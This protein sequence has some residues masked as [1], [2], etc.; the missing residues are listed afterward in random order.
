MAVIGFVLI[1]VGF[2]LTA[3]S[4]SGHPTPY[5]RHHVFTNCVLPGA[6]VST[7]AFPGIVVA[8]IFA[9]IW[10]TIAVI[11][12][13]TWRHPEPEW[14]YWSQ[15]SWSQ[16]AI[17]DVLVRG[18]GV[19][20]TRRSGAP[21]G[22]PCP[23]PQRVRRLRPQATRTGRDGG[24]QKKMRVSRIIIW[25]VVL[26]PLSALTLVSGGGTA[27]A[28]V[29]GAGIENCTGASGSIKYSPAWSDADSSSQIKAK[30]KITFSGCS[31]GTP[32]ASQ[33]NA[34]GTLKF[35]P[36]QSDNECT[37]AEEAGAVGSLKLKYNGGVSPSTYTGTIWVSNPTDPYFE[38]ESGN[39]VVTGS[40][41]NNGGLI[42]G[43]PELV[44]DE[45]SAVGNCTTGV[46]SV[47]LG[48][49]A[50]ALNI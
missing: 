5:C 7:I 23:S 40:Y 11:L 4:G 38:S 39:D 26:L 35:T 31:G 29:P 36:S 21:L 37:N 28:A 22:A 1:E 48:G 24:R 43:V 14:P 12:V 46:K 49:S 15:S 18:A 17:S 30:I 27:G 34:T 44:V 32:L 13:R 6:N 33:F 20:P 10:S 19:S 3:W 42:I 47:V 9:A 50:E 8:A 16:I 45:V 25:T 41:P 2:G